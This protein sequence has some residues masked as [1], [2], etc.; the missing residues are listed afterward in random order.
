MNKK[1]KKDKQQNTVNTD[2]EEKNVERGKEKEKNP[3]PPKKTNEK[4][5]KI[6]KNRKLKNRLSLRKIP[7]FG[8]MV[9]F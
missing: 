2:K 6:L 9:S 1:K 8:S 3:F 4:E 7:V 5:I